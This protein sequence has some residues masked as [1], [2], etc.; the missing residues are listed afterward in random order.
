VVLR[1][2]HQGLAAAADG[3]SVAGLH[4]GAPAALSSEAASTAPA[5]L[6]GFQPRSLPPAARHRGIGAC[7][8]RGVLGSLG[9][10]FQGSSGLEAPMVGPT[11]P[12]ARSRPSRRSIGC[13]RRS[14]TV[15]AAYA[16]GRARS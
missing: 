4:P 11:P 10:A 3:S 2:E 15:L 8:P 1:L 14:G 9:T 13:R 7:A 5:E 6:C 12:A 16:G